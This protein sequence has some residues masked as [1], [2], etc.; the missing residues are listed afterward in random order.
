[1][2]VDAPVA[3]TCFNKAE[4][5]RPLRNVGPQV[6][7]SENSATTLYPD[8]FA[9]AATWFLCFSE[10]FACRPFLLRRKKA[11]AGFKSFFSRTMDDAA[12]HC[13]AKFLQKYRR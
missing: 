12:K 11:T 13:N 5:P 3:S 9:N 6:I 2:T 8:A 7:A 4:N 1:M 10:G